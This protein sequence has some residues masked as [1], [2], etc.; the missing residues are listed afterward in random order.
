MLYLSMDLDQAYNLTCEI[1]KE[2]NLLMNGWSFVWLRSKRVF[3]NCN[4]T[5]KTIGLSAKLVSLNSEAAVRNTI[6]HEIAHA[7]TPKHGH[8]Y[9]WRYKCLALGGDGKRVYSRANVVT[10][11]HKF[12][13]RCDSHNITF[14]RHRK[15]SKDS[16][17]KKCWYINGNLCE[18]LKWKIIENT[19]LTVDK[20]PVILNSS[21]AN[22]I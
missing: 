16:Y 6:L 9:V 4:Y 20:I 21:N 8:D 14:L 15:S 12:S 19:P 7:L 2:H 3:G 13:A 1:M 5:F 11:P 18:P 17:C 10:P 22:S